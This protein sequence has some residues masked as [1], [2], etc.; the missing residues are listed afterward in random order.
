MPNS[1]Q[2]CNIPAVE[3]KGGLSALYPAGTCMGKFCLLQLMFT[4]GVAARG[5][6]QDT[7]NISEATSSEI[8]LSPK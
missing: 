6:I 2:T 1:H 3:H 5:V 7:H 4:L 8:K